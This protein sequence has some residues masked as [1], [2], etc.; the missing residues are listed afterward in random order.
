V[1]PGDVVLHC[2][3]GRRMTVESVD[4]LVVRCMWFEGARL[5]QRDF[6]ASFLVAEGMALA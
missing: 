3:S 1:S 6:A 4:G 5:V 2:R